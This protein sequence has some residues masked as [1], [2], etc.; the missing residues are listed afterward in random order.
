MNDGEAM[1]YIF[2]AISSIRNSYNI[3]MD[4]LAERLP[5]V[6]VYLPD[7]QLESPGVLR[8]RWK[9]LDLE[10]EVAKALVQCRLIF[11]KGQLRISERCRDQLGFLDELMAMLMGVWRYV[12]FS[13]S[14]WLTMGR[15]ARAVCAGILTGIESLIRYSRQV[16][17]CSE[18][19]IHGV[20]RLRSP[21][22]GLC[23]VAAVST[24]IAETLMAELLEDDRLQLCVL[25]SSAVILILVG[26]VE[27]LGEPMSVAQ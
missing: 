27:W 24:C 4:N 17:H 1:N 26:N 15:S 7:Q 10:P 9:T 25:G 11:C 13:D 14:R 23:A 18:Y 20:D 16:K 8:E 5:T 6:L 22:R 12:T 3:L 2:V 19:Y 21:V